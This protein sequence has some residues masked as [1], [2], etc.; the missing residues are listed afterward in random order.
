MTEISFPHQVTRVST[1]EAGMTAA[2]MSAETMMDFFIR[3]WFK[4]MDRVG[5][6]SETVGQLYVEPEVR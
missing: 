4:V 6:F 3:F 2:A 5:L 1:A